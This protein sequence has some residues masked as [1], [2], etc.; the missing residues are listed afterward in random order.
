MNL[1]G[2]GRGIAVWGKQTFMNSRQVWRMKERNLFYTRKEEIWEG[3]FEQKFIGEG[4]GFEVVMVSHW[5]RAVVSVL[6]LGHGEIFLL[7][8]KSRWNSCVKNVLPCENNS[9]LPS[10]CWRCRLPQV[11]CRESSLQGLPSFIFTQVRNHSP[12]YAINTE[13]FLHKPFLPI[14]K[15]I[16]KSATLN[17]NQFQAGKVKL[18]T[19][20]L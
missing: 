16:S 2:N 3:C 7:F 18:D 5:L 17:Y 8:V 1:F 9:S 20:R 19:C 10:C 13:D 12:I 4:Q 6:L 11:V 15:K 14:D